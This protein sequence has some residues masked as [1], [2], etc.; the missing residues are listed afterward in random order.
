[1]HKIE[2]IEKALNLLD[3]YDGQLSKTARALVINRYT[4]RSWRDKRKKE[5]PLISRTRNK[6][7]KWSKEEQESA[8]EYYFSHGENITKA[9]KKF[10]YPSASSLKSWV[11]KKVLIAKSL[12][13]KAHIYVRDEPLNY[14]DLYSRLQIEKLI[15]QY[16]PTMILVP[17]ICKCRCN[18]IRKNR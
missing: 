1:M 9:C 8:I 4:L 11:K 14:I 10:G 3:T 18:K 6:S 5:E 7:S 2:E 13:G 17:S 16:N 15:K 12:C